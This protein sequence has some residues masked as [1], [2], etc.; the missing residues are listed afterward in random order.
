[1]SRESKF[2][3]YLVLGLGVLAVISVLVLAFSGGPDTSDAE[4]DP[5]VTAQLQNDIEGNK[6]PVQQTTA[7]PKP[8]LVMARQKGIDLSDLRG[9]WKSAS[10]D[11]VLVMQMDKGA[12]QIILAPMDANLPRMYSSGSYTLLD[13]IVILKPR[14][15]W[16]APPAPQGSDIRYE[17][18]AR[19]QYAMIVGFKDGAMIWQDVPQSEKRVSIARSPL[20]QD[21]SL[22]YIVWKKLD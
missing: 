6:A 21:N 2:I 5:Q 7:K 16:K 19:G 9:G 8:E 1:M 15:D 20:L 10:G 4:I 18:L 3:G 12:F 17:R 14:S 13:D 11:Y 22:N